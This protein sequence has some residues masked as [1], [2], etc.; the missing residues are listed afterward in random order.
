MKLWVIIGS[1]VF[2]ISIVTVFLVF[3][4]PALSNYTND[5][6]NIGGEIVPNDEDDLN[7][8]DNN[9]LIFSINITKFFVGDILDIEKFFVSSNLNDYEIFIK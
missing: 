5:N 9:V 8:S 4:L 7:N 6:T 1:I 3:G 2:S